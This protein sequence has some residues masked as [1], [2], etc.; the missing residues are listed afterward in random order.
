MGIGPAF[1]LAL[2]SGLSRPMTILGVERA[3]GAGWCN[4]DVAAAQPASW[5]FIPAL[6]V[7]SG[8]KS[9]FWRPVKNGELGKNGKNGNKR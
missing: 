5:R 2:P 6:R 3:G 4:D 9:S 8:A 7:A 1:G